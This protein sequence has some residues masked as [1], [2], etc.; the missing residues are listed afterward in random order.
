MTRINVVPVQELCNQHL[1]AEWREMPR[2]RNNLQQSLN[3]KVPFNVNEIPPEYVLGKGHVKFFYDKFKY[4]H[5]R[6]IEI[7]TELIKR[8]YKLSQKDSHIF[9]YVSNMWYKV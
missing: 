7:T 4:L 2:L 9:S 6:H 8:G 5:I 1:F 3:R